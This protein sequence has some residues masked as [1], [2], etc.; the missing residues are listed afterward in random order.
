M[1]YIQW[2]TFL[3]YGLNFMKHSLCWRGDNQVHP[4]RYHDVVLVGFSLAILITVSYSYAFF[5][6]SSLGILLIGT[7]IMILNYQTWY[8]YTG[9]ENNPYITSVVLLYM[10]NTSLKQTTEAM[11]V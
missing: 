1:K 3:W 7:Y 10:Y 11:F 9:S 6:V 4:N 8:K 2:T 5:S